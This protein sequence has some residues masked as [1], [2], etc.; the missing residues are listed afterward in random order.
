MRMSR[1]FGVTLRELSSEIEVSSHRLL[2]QEAVVAEHRRQRDAREAAARLP[3]ELAPRTAAE[4]GSIRLGLVHGSLRC[5][6][7][8]GSRWSPS[9]SRQSR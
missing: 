3:E 5:G 2:L 6:R 9:C 1:Y 8:S 7:G 4:V